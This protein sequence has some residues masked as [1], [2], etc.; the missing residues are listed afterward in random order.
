[1]EGFEELDSE[2]K[3]DAMYLFEGVST[4]PGGSGG[5]IYVQDDL[6]N[7]VMS[8]IVSA[9]KGSDGMIVRGFDEEAWE[10]V[11][12][13]NFVRNLGAM[14]RVTTCPRKSMTSVEWSWIGAITLPRNQAT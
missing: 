7:W 1:L 10:L 5:P 4:Y 2:G 11:E 13:A 3:W 8:G 12:Q 9:K 14:R 6:D